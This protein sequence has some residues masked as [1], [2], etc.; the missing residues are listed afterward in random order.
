MIRPDKTLILK[1]VKD[2]PDFRSVFADITEK[3]GTA[4]P[5]GGTSPA[6]AR[7]PLIDPRV[8]GCGLFWFAPFK[9]PYPIRLELGAMAKRA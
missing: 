9:Q 5:P 7:N 2:P 4:R 1:L 6:G 3:R 8:L